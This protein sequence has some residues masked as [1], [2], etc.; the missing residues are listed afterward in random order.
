MQSLLSHFTGALVSN[1]SVSSHQR[2][3]QPQLPMTSLQACA[4]YLASLEKLGSYFP[5]WQPICQ[6]KVRLPDLATL[7]LLFMRLLHEQGT[8]LEGGGDNGSPVWRSTRPC[9][10]DLWGQSPPST[11]CW[12]GPWTGKTERKLHTEKLSRAS[13]RNPHFSAGPLGL[14]IPGKMKSSSDT[15]ESGQIATQV[16]IPARRTRRKKATEQLSLF[17]VSKKSRPLICLYLIMRPIT[18]CTTFSKKNMRWF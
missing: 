18:C 1:P 16:T 10:K 9:S 14:I 2:R 8:V 7:W 6:R 5:E 15:V 11:A 12:S 13:W 3:N 4:K 17:I